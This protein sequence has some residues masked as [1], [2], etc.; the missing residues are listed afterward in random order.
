MNDPKHRVRRRP[1]QRDEVRRGLLI[2]L[3][4]FLILAAAN[5]LK[6]FDTSVLRHR[7]ISERAASQHMRRSVTYPM[8][9][10]I[11]DSQ[12]KILVTTTYVYTIGITPAD[13]RSRTEK[14][15]KE[16]ITEYI[17]T[18][19][20]LDVAET[21]T[22][23]NRVQQP[24]V[25]LKKN[26]DRDTK[27]K[28]DDY[29]SEHAIGGFAI[30][31]VMQRYYPE[32]N[33][34]SGV[35]GF[36]NR[37]EDNIQGIMG[38]ERSYDRELTGQ[39]GYRYA[40]VDNYLGT[41]L[42]NTEAVEV[43]AV[44]GNHLKIN[45][46][47]KIQNVAQ[48]V[49]DAL[50][51]GFEA[52]KGVFAVV[53]D[54]KTGAVW[55]MADSRSFDLNN[56]AGPPPG[57]HPDD[58]NPAEN[59][60]QINHLTSN[61]WVNQSTMFPYEPGSSFKPLTASIGLDEGKVDLE[62]YFSDEPMWVGDWTEY[63]IS[64]WSQEYDW[65]HGSVN[66]EEALMYSCNPPFVRIA[67][68]IGVT[69]FYDYINLMGMNERTGIDLPAESVGLVHSEPN[70]V[71][72]AT[73]AFGE[74]STITGIRQAQLYAA[75][76]NEGRLMTP[77]IADSLLDNDGNVVRQFKPEVQRRI[78]SAETTRLV[79][80]R[81]VVGTHFGGVA[82]YI[83]FPGHATAG[84]TGTS[85]APYGTEENASTFSV[86][87]IVPYDDPKFVVMMS[88]QV[89]RDNENS[90][91]LQQG[92]RYITRKVMEEM[93]FDPHW[94][95]Y[96]W[97]HAWDQE[98]IPSYNYNYTFF[99]ALVD[100]TTNRSVQVRFPKGIRGDDLVTQMWPPGGSVL[101]ADG[102]IFL[103]TEDHPLPEN[104]TAPTQVPDFQGLGLFEMRKLA[105]E[106]QINVNYSGFNPSGQV[107]YQSVNPGTEVSKWSV[108][109]L[110]FS[111]ET[112]A[113]REIIEYQKREDSSTIEDLP[114]TQPPAGESPTFTPENVA[115]TDTQEVP[116]VPAETVP[117]NPDALP[118]YSQESTDGMIPAGGNVPETPAETE[119][120]VGG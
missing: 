34:A 48:E 19:L 69:K 70:I 28:L 78:Y 14:V 119:E 52:K 116:Q 113:D 13:V 72:M 17:A 110:A 64:C 4:F 5:I 26:V 84:K 97:V 101:N 1:G 88:L 63:P 57:I 75:L 30:D 94:I 65:N 66:L 55:A 91:A 67:Q 37:I 18:L 39:P 95:E 56:P 33:F 8:R 114:M 36:T 90:H 93:E 2:A 24:Y 40:E 89:P 58:W 117:F 32:K 59:Q 50:A 21:A 80:E 99:E 25:Q 42:P 98:M 38:L 7:E 6:L 106:A 79:L 3:A 87:A 12:G 43:P 22:N 108:V 109:S 71:D 9:G 47:S 35:I 10:N 73:L 102:F 85:L 107:V 54:A 100:A 82:P 81:M 118:E 31:P 45:I 96:D 27:E 46:N 23:M 105:D 41:R 49:V 11:V 60:E 51:I 74:Q 20:D 86:G 16:E 112:P 111:D 104:L 53:M 62:E 76:A 92:S 68:R 44:D 103:G 83:Y 29:L 61:V 115:D 120:Q 15:T 77:R